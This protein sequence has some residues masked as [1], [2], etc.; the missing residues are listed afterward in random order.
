M[1]TKFYNHIVQLQKTI[2]D[3]FEQ[4]DEK[5]RFFEDKWTRDGG[6]GGI[7]KIIE[8]GKVIEKGG[9]NISKVFGELPQSMQK[10]LN[11]KSNKFFACGLSLVI[12]PKNPMVP[13]VH[14]NWRYFEMYD[15][16][17]DISDSWFGGGQDLTP[18]YIF[19]D[20]IQHF[21][22]QCKAICDK[23]NPSFYIKFKENCDNYFYNSHRSEAR[24]VGGLFFDY[25]KETSTTKMSDWYNFIEEISSNFIKSYAPIINRKKLSAYSK[26]NKEWQEIRRGRYVEFNLV[27]DKGT[28]FGLKTNGRI[29]SILMSLPPKVSW[30]YNFVPA[31]NSEESKLIDILKNPVKWV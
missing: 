30:K 10:Q 4:I 16:D 17:G 29:E 6:G 7:T 22:K 18:Y 9:V 8:D 24:G 3:E 31:K 25:C 27:H 1:K 13:T 21:H 14:A 19:E 20:D 11:T 23:H 5:A 12:H 15:D 26:S 28:L 2:C